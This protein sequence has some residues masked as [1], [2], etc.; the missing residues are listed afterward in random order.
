MS[1]EEGLNDGI[2]AVC[3]VILG[4]RAC[5]TDRLSEKENPI[6]ALGVLILN[7]IL[8]AIQENK[9]TIIANRKRTYSEKEKIQ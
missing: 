5:A 4:M 7:E 9:N 8:A 1:Y 3:N 6:D 2:E